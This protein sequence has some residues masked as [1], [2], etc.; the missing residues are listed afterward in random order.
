MQDKRYRLPQGGETPA[1]MVF[2]AQPPPAIG[3]VLV[4]WTNNGP[5]GPKLAPLSLRL[6][7]VWL[8]LIGG[9]VLGLIGFFVVGGILDIESGKATADAFLYS[10]AGGA[11][12][13]V[14]LGLIRM[15]RPP[16]VLTLFVGTDGCVQIERFGAAAR[17]HLLDFREVEAMRTHVSVMTASGIRTTMRELHMRP[18]GGKERLWYVT[19]A[20]GQQKPDDPQYYFGEAVLAAFEAHR[21]RRGDAEAIAGTWRSP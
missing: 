20:P 4:A 15:R 11:L 18:R 10:L 16:Q 8:G 1:D 9:F 5:Q 6:S 7:S 12:L 13:G 2:R 21:V 19:A 3:E 14:L 17:E